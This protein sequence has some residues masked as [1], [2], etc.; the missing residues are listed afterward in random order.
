MW[1]LG[2]L[3]RPH[4]F[5]RMCHSCIPR[6]LNS[7]TSAEKRVTSYLS[8]QVS[9]PHTRAQKHT[10][11]G[12]WLSDENK[13]NILIFIRITSKYR[14]TMFAVWAFTADKASLQHHRLWQQEARERVAV[15]KL[16]PASM[17]V[18]CFLTFS[19]LE[20]SREAF[21]QRYRISLCIWV[22]QAGSTY[23]NVM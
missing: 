2:K 10:H 21:D 13:R 16:K 11:T 7:C 6:L 3:A 12:F 22:N 23:C 1:H 5:C 20:Q 9:S 15:T 4:F 19:S 17:K 14:A 8:T 18:N